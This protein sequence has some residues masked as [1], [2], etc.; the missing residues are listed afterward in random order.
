MWLWLVQPVYIIVFNSET[1]GLEMN[2]MFSHENPTKWA[3]RCK[4][5][6]CDVLQMKRRCESQ[7]KPVIFLRENCLEEEGGGDYFPL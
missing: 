7:Y 3:S 6:R 5:K 4:R 1:R 2:V